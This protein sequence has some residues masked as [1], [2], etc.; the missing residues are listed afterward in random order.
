[1]YGHLLGIHAPKYIQKNLKNV[2]LVQLCSCRKIHSKEIQKKVKIERSGENP[3]NFFSKRG[4]K[5]LLNKKI[6]IFFAQK[7]FNNRKEYFQRRKCLKKIFKSQKIKKIEKKKWDFSAIFISVKGLVTFC[8][9]KNL[10]GVFG[11]YIHITLRLKPICCPPP[12]A[13]LI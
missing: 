12:P 1:M 5:T 10:G 8:D 4:F 2:L 13:L 9:K 3:P 6:F 7:H 11:D